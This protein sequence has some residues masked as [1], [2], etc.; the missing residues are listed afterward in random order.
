MGFIRRMRR[1]VTDRVC[2]IG[3]VCAGIALV[4]WTPAGPALGGDISVQDITRL[5]GHGSDRLWGMGLVM[6][7]P[8]TGDSAD[9]LPRARQIAKLMEHAG[10][11]VPGLEEAM[12]ASSVAIVM[13]TA[14]LP[15]GGV[16]AADEYHLDVQTMFDAKS[17]EGGSLFLTPMRG[18]LP[19]DP[20]IYALGAG[21]LSFDSA[22]TTSA[23]VPNGCRIIRD[24]EKPVVNGEG[25]LT[26]QVRENYASMTTTTLIASLINQD[27][28][29]LRADGA[30]PIARARN[31]RS[32]EVIIPDEELA[33]PVRFIADLQKITFDESLMHM[34]PRIVI[35]EQ[36]GLITITGNVVIKPSVISSG[37]LVV[38][39]IEPEIPATPENPEIRQSN[40]ML[41]A[42]TDDTQAVAQA[43]SLLEAM[44]R[45]EVPVQ[46][47]I[48][49]FK[50]LE[51]GSA[52]SVPLEFQ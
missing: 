44:R 17:L 29:G 51:Q 35:N 27:R 6:G 2:P 47:Q 30:R 48:Q 10:N 16:V 50:A 13:V 4:G 9:L 26:F 43:Q 39:T 36:V 23:R 32:V 34:R 1:L 33:N 7:L 52:L 40:S 46:E 3:L 14:R 24:I 11:P 37:K 18:S 22:I 20:H 25:R 12:E 42:A 19:T 28:Q 38:T 8:G 5:K 49:M 45:M 15:E 21:K 41:F 31:E